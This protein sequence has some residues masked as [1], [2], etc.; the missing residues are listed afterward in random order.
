MQIMRENFEGGVDD[1]NILT[2]C[3][4]LLISSSW[5]YEGLV[6]YVIYLG[7]RRNGPVSAGSA[8]KGI[9]CQIGAIEKVGILRIEVYNGVGQRV[10]VRI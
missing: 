9:F 2:F 8:E 10:R 5:S 3:G 4:I 1:H 7:V 6:P